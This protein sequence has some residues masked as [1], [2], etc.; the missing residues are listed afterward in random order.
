MA[1]ADEYA[2]L[3]I[4][5]GDIETNWRS[6]VNEKMVLIQPVLDELNAK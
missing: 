2:A 3:V 6:W 1:M 4:K 5:S